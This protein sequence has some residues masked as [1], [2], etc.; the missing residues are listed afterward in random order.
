MNAWVSFR[1]N[2]DF[3]SALEAWSKRIRSRNQPVF[4]EPSPGC[5]SNRCGSS[6]WECQLQAVRG[7][8]G[9]PAGL[10]RMHQPGQSSG[11]PGS[12][13]LGCDRQEAVFCKD[14]MD[15]C[16][17]STVWESVNLKITEGFTELES[18]RGGLFDSSCAR[19][20]SFQRQSTQYLVYAQNN[21]GQNQHEPKDYKEGADSHHDKHAPTG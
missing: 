15:S 11:Q 9:G 5:R 12:P 3:V 18:T 10:T 17:W 19:V 13:Y 2:P 14:G 8:D 4:T 7:G 21:G 20:K 1:T 6:G 16:L